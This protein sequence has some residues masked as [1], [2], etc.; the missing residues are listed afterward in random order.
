[1]ELPSSKFLGDK[2]IHQFINIRYNKPDKFR[3]QTLTEKQ[4]AQD[5]FQWPDVNPG[6]YHA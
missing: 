5:Q 1:M 2:Q 4:T 3:S 6:C